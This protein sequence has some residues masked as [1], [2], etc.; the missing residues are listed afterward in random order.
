MPKRKAARKR[1]SRKRPKRRPA[2]KPKRRQTAVAV[3]DAVRLPAEAHNQISR[4]DPKLAPGGR[5]TEAIEGIVCSIRDIR[6]G[7]LVAKTRG[8]LAGFVL[9]ILHAQTFR[10]QYS[11]EKNVAGAAAS[12][13]PAH[14]PLWSRLRALLQEMAARGELVSVSSGG[15]SQ[16]PFASLLDGWRVV[17]VKAEAI[18]PLA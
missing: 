10:L 2:A 14:N 5:S 6:S 1:A 8:D 17:K 13:I 12:G 16:D 11:S 18:E 9:E 3:G 15:L 7:K 4:Y